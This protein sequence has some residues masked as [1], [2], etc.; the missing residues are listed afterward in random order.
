[1]PGRLAF[2]DGEWKRGRYLLIDLSRSSS[3]ATAGERSTALRLLPR[4]GSE[5]GVVFAT[6]GRP[7]LVWS[8]K[9][10]DDAREHESRRH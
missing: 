4:T 2:Y 8:A 3:V 5:L 6:A 7:R 9:S 1:V 10:R